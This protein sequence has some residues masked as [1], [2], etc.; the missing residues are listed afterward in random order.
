MILDILIIPIRGLNY[1]DDSSICTP[2]APTTSG[3]VNSNG[4]TI[5]FMILT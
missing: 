4:F 2:V 1:T 3:R 5:R